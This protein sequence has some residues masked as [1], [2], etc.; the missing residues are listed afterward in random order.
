MLFSAVGFFFLVIH[1]MNDNLF[2]SN[3][4]HSIG[5]EVVDMHRVVDRIIDENMMGFLW[6][7]FYSSIA[8]WGGGLFQF[9]LKS[10]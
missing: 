1:L 6:I 7:F 4:A 8:S 9:F 5:H 3:M 10:L 2:N